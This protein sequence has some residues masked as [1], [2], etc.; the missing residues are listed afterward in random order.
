VR[1]D[2]V[3]YEVTKESESPAKPAFELL[4]RKE[5]MQSLA[6]LR[7]RTGLSDMVTDR[8]MSRYIRR[9]SSERRFGVAAE[10]GIGDNWQASEVKVNQTARPSQN[11]TQRTNL[12]A[13]AMQTESF[14]VEKV[15]V[16]VQT[17]PDHAQQTIDKLKR[18]LEE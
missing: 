13:K 7:L 5:N 12:K 16:S 4:N 17:L 14:T 1:Y 8:S 6:N 11:F 3:I 2:K 10:V 18:R 9:R 15:E